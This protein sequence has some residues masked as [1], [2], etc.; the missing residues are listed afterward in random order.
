MSAGDLLNRTHEELILLLIQLRKDTSSTARLIEK[1]CTEIH[2]IQVFIILL[3]ILLF[4][5]LEL[6]L[7]YMF[8][9]FSTMVMVIGIQLDSK[10][11]SS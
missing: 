6:I 8:I 11:K 9:L 1:C 5:P 2:N 7:F 4:N 3:F 10:N